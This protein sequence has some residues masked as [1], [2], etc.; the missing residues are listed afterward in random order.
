VA[1]LRALAA[2]ALA[3]VAGLGLLMLDSGPGYDDTALT[4]I[5]LALAAF[6]V[7]LIDGSG[8]VLRVATLAVL[9]GIWIPVL[10]IAP[11]GTYGPLLAL[12][13]AAAGAIAGML[14]LRS[15]W[16][17]REAPPAPSVPPVPP[18][19]SAPSGPSVPPLEPPSDP[20]LSGPSN[21]RD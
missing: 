21:D 6:A 1:A 8:R 7:V 10:E 18:G 16:P 5:G 4:A 13:F 3:I 19:P 9:V 17:S 2:I 12:A 20:P 15:V 11:P 14:V